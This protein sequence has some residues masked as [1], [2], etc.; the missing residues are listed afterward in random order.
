MTKI[1]DSWFFLFD[2]YK[3]DTSIVGLINHAL[4]VKSVVSVRDESYETLLED[5]TSLLPNNIKDKS[6][7]NFLAYVTKEIND[8]I[9]EDIVDKDDAEKS[10]ESENT[11]DEEKRLP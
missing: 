3:Y 4:G 1:A 7:E 8:F 5:I 2:F 10:E 6:Y 11:S 9:F